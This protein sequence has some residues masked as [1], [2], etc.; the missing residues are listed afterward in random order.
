MEFREKFPNLKRVTVTDRRVGL[1]GEFVRYMWTEEQWN[2]ESSAN[3]NDWDR[4]WKAVEK[5]FEGRG[6]RIEASSDVPETNKNKKRYIK[7]F[8]ACP[9]TLG[10]PAGDI[11]AQTR[12]LVRE[13][14]AGGVISKW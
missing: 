14:G 10:R 4:D 1:N 7:S 12:M 5:L 13:G 8:Q 2:R 11:P 3:K 6:I 9:V